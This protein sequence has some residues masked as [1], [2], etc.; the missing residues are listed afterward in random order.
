[1]YAR[2]MQTYAYS[3]LAKMIDH[4]LLNPTLTEEA[5]KAGCELAL[6]YDVASVCIMPYWL[7]PCAQILR[8]S[9]VAPSTT[10]GFPHGG[11]CLTT[12]LAGGPEGA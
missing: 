2:G 1:M 8:G 10:V 7:K 11:H 4:S 9:N 3:D 6:A 5:L 12:K